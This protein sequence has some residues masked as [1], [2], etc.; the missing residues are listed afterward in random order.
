MC[1]QPRDELDAFRED[2]EARFKSLRCYLVKQQQQQSDAGESHFLV[3]PKILPCSHSA[4]YECI[5]AALVDNSLTCAQ[6]NTVHTDINVAQLKTNTSLVD[7]IELNSNEITD[8]MIE[9][10]FKYIQS[11]NGLYSNYIK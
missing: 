9:Q 2:F 3:E 11:L 4:C 6:C 1:E 10:L 5:Q 7:Q 8:Q